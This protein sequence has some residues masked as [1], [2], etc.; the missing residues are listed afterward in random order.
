M[1]QT[2]QK[3]TWGKF[4]L[5]LGL[6]TAVTALFVFLGT[7]FLRVLRGVFG[8]VKYWLSGIVVTGL[9][10]TASPN[11]VFL[12]LL[13]LSLWVTVGIYRELEERGAGNFWGALLSVFIGSLL[14][15][16]GPQLWALALGQDFAAS[17]KSSFEELTQKF[18]EGKKLS[19]YGVSSEAI[20]G[21][22]PSVL[23]VLQIAGLAFALMLDRRIARLLNLRF[24][25]VASQMRLLEFRLPDFMI[26]LTMFSFL[27]SFIKLNNETVSMVALNV[28]NVMMGLYFFQGLAVLEVSFLAFRVGSFIKFLI[29]FIVIGQLFFLLSA[30]GVID[31]W[32]DFRQRFKRWRMSEK[33][34]K[35]GE[36]V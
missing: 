14:M 18:F 3:P 17:L 33:N 12:A 5:V 36:N 15:I 28:F 29:Y 26:W 10:I 32:M 13:V 19:E 6:A 30:V 35:N 4:F 2:L 11:T 20:I 25:K 1:S 23:I 34:P 24:E 22:L 7:P 9:L 31:Y 27:L 8:P 21:Q 16:W